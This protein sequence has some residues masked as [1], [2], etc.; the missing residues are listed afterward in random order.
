MKRNFVVAMIPCYIAA[1]ICLIGIAFYSSRVVTVYTR[2]AIESNRTCVVIDAGHGGEDGGA[3]SVSGEFESN[4]NLEI[5]IK[6]NDLMHLLGI[7]TNMIRTDDRSIYTKGTTLS[8]KKISDLKE[9]VRI[10]NQTNNPIL[11]SIHQNYFSN[12]KY[13]GMQ[14][15]FANTQGSADLAMDLQNK[16]KEF[17]N[18]NNNRKI[19]KTDS[20][21]L[22]EKINCT[23][24]LVECGFLSNY[25]E[26]AKLRNDT[27]QTKIAGLIA[28]TLCN[29]LD[30]CNSN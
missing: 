29:Y 8:E 10:I 15:F 20:V 26:E 27:Y 16:S 17:L 21:Y 24:V 2:N 22:M 19:K 7:K 1:M 28:V 3:I 30:R 11:I 23:A 6:T 25:A 12:E 14:V 13:S 5:A 9:R 4:I 18:P